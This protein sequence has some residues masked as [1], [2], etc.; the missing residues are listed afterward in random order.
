MT[1]SRTNAFTFAF[2]FALALPFPL[3]ALIHDVSVDEDHKV[4]FRF[5]IEN[6]TTGV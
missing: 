2:A 4:M 6:I 1:S 3:L 5:S